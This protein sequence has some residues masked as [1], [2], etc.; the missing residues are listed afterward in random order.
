MF[1]VRDDSS[2]SVLPA[3]SPDRF[4]YHG[5]A[6]SKVDAPVTFPLELDP[7]L[8]SHDCHVT[9]SLALAACVCHFGCKWECIT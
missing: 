1:V 6:G 5:T 9:E 2:F 7:R 3:P 8:V 4:M